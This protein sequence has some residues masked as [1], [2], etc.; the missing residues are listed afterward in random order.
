MSQIAGQ[1]RRGGSI[2]NQP[3]HV[4]EMCW[5]ANW[6]KGDDN[7]AFTKGSRQQNLLT[8][9]WDQIKLEV[10]HLNISFGR[11]LP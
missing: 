8:F 1:D 3:N 10:F 11:D 4:E 6:I 9:P 5:K 7:I 2:I